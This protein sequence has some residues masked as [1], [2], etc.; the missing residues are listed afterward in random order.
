MTAK[1]FDQV[2]FGFGFDATFI[3]P[4]AQQVQWFFRQ[5]QGFEAGTRELV[6]VGSANIQLEILQCQSHLIDSHELN[7]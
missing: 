1:I 3:G 4:I 7:V 5:G 2:A 6:A